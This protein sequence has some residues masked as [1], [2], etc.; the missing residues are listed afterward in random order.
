MKRQ[1]EQYIKL[2]EARCYHDGI[3]DDVPKE[4]FDRVPSYRN[5]AIAILKNDISLL[6]IEPPKK[7]L[8]YVALKRIE[9]R[10]RPEY[11]AS[12]QLKLDLI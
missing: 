10:S 4:I 11:V 1:V 6:G 7:S 8:F 5:I 12:T 2:W 3:P 9:I